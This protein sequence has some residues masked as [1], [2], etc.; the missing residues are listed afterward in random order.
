MA[1]CT[2]VHR[3]LFRWNYSSSCRI[4]P[5]NPGVWLNQTNPFGGMNSMYVKKTPDPNQEITV[6]KLWE[7][8]GEAHNNKSSGPSWQ[9]FHDWVMRQGP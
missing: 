8:G 1:T 5:V 7:V 3:G 9:L 4:L 2:P 6:W